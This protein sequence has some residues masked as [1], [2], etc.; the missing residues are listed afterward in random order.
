MGSN[1]R[2]ASA[3][4][5]A[6]WLDLAKAALGDQYPATDVY[7]LDWIAR[8]LDPASGHETWVAD[9]DGVL[10]ASACFLGVEGEKTNP[11]A[12]LGRLLFRSDSYSD[13]SAHALLLSLNELAAQRGEAVTEEAGLFGRLRSSRS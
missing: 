7:D 4:D 11:V 12:N 2:P 6:Q 3:A 1:I 8:Q 5:A 10:Q 13:G 9:V